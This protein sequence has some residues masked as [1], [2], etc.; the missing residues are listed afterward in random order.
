M[1][2]PFTRMSRTRADIRILGMVA[3][4]LFLAGCAT[5]PNTGAPPDGPTAG[6]D[7]TQAAQ[8]VVVVAEPPKAVE[9]APDS[10]V[11]GFLDDLVSDEQDYRTAKE[12]LTPAAATVWN[13]QQKVVVLRDIRREPAK[14]VGGTATVTI[15]GT[16]IAALNDRHA[17]TAPAT[18]KFSTTITM[19]KNPQGVYRI[20]GP[21]TGIILNEQDFRRI[22]EPVNLYFPVARP[23]DDS[24]PPGP[25]PMAADP[26][27][28]R[29]HI[30]PLTEAAGA[31]VGGPGAWLSPAVASGFPA[32]A[33]LGGTT[34]SV[35][36]E[37]GVR[38]TFGGAI[39][40][41][42]AD[43]N[44]C[45]RMAAQLYFTLSEVPTQ[46]GTPQITSV[47]LTRSGSEA[48]TCSVI[49]SSR[50]T[51]FT[52]QNQS[53]AYYV[54]VDG[55][56]RSLNTTQP[57][58]DST[59]VT[60]L[61]APVSAGHLSGFAVAPDNSG[62]VAVL[63]ANGRDLYASTLTSQK[64]PDRPVLSSHATDGSGLSSPSWDGLGTLWVADTDPKASAVWAVI[65]GT[66]VKVPVTGL[67]G[68]VQGVRV[69]IDGARI[70]LT[71][72]NPD[73]SAS[74]VIGRIEQSRAAS[75]P[76]LTIDG[77][78]PM[79]TL[80]SV[81]SVAWDDADSVVVLGQPSS[82][83]K[84]LSV[85]EVDGS[86]ELAQPAQLP[87]AVDGMV[88]VGAFQPFSAKQQATKPPM[89]GDSFQAAAPAVRGNVYVLLKNQPQLVAS[90][91]A[92][93][94]AH[95]N[96]PMPSYPG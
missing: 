16:Q 51:P 69:S 7:S 66:A 39:G 42:L 63:S 25:S 91:G 10:L 46:P 18:A 37:G 78:M 32:G 67:Q 81:N 6:G 85:W 77:L 29:S 68:T 57:K 20:S 87:A 50:Y 62:R 65:G 70:A 72:K 55:R 52:G 41:A 94:S 93:D 82:S 76:K 14:V 74:V 23:G 8:Q 19:V 95:G 89:L 92:N 33:S 90:N 96:G 60:G 53:T 45:E 4:G 26:I 30:D 22:Y 2:V 17:Y 36:A 80:S 58:P 31:L 13:P 47:A 88:T 12:F 21:P 49:S 71:V 28:V 83:A 43:Q 64:S 44:L 1:K 27:Y 5:M 3:A 24:T 34:V 84:G 73:G 56:L 61:L 38:F 54:D 9:R 86:S 40:T 48:S 35:G 79:V 59:L 11:A 75:T 15:T